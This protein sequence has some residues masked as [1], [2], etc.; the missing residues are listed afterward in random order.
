M[1]AEGKRRAAFRAGFLG[2]RT[3][4]HSTLVA[5]SEATRRELAGL[6]HRVEILSGPPYPE[7]DARVPLVKVPSL[8][9]YRE[10]D[11]FRTPRPSEFRDRIGKIAEMN[12][13]RRAERQ[14]EVREADRRLRRVHDRML[15]WAP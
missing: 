13:R 11:P 3:L 4:G 9:L 5:V 2:V 7:L 6:G 15:A 12:R 8:D 10:P 14:N 1:E